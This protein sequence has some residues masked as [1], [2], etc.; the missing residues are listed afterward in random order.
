MANSG[1][2]EEDDDEDDDEDDEEDVDGNE[3]TLPILR[4]RRTVEGHV[5]SLETHFR[6]A[7]S[8]ISVW[9]HLKNMPHR[10]Q[11]EDSRRVQSLMTAFD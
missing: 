11:H 6:Q 2:E 10:Q 7:S 1:D 5:G 4:A 3:A 9:S 8:L